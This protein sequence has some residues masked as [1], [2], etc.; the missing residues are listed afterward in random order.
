MLARLYVI[1]SS[2]DKNDE[3]AVKNHFL[4]IC[5]DF[6]ISASRECP[7]VKNAIDFYI[8]MDINEDDVPYLLDKLNNDWDGENDQCS[9]YGFNTKM[10]NP[11]IYYL[12]FTLWN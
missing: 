6:S 12:D 1:V 3:E 9:C 8:T 11:L 5:P 7:H 10:F 2:T 4:E